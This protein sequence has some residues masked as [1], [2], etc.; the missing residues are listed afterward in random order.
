MAALEKYTKV[1]VLKITETQ[2]KTLKKLQSYSVPVSQFIRDAIK[3]KIARDHKD[4]LP[5]PKQQYCPF[6]NGQIKL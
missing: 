4:L 2:H 3:E 5:K 1:K 6:S